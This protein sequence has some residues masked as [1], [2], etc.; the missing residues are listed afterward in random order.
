MFRRS[1]GNMPTSLRTV[2]L[3][4]APS[5]VWFS[6]EDGAKSNHRNVI[7]NK[8]ISCPCRETNPG[9]PAR[10]PWPS[11]LQQSWGLGFKCRP[12]DRPSWGTSRS[13]SVTPRKQANSA[14]TDCM[15]LIARTV[16]HQSHFIFVK[17]GDPLNRQ[18]SN[19]LVTKE[20]PLTI[21]RH[22]YCDALYTWRR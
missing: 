16:G 20:N 8:K 19:T 5:W 21:H 15:K 17:W 22:D 4:I 2:V 7:L 11:R 10:S 9:S 18:I 6:P 14:A 12:G 3:S 1:S 13:N